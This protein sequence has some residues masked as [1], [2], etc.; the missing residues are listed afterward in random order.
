[1]L[2]LDKVLLGKVLL[3]KVLLVKVL[4]GKV[5]LVKVLLVEMWFV[6]VLHPRWQFWGFTT[7]IHTQALLACQSSSR[8][9]LPKFPKS[10]FL[11]NLVVMSC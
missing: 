2:V 3:G 11:L 6:K 1:M 7:R 8:D 9:C 5:L 10:F 4:L